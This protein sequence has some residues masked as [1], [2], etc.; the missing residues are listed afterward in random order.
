MST[1]PAPNLAQVSVSD[2]VYD[3]DDVLPRNSPLP[4]PHRLTLQLSPSPD[5]TVSPSTASPPPS[6]GKKRSNRRKKAMPQGYA[7][8][9]GHLDGHRQ[10]SAA[11]AQIEPYISDGEDA[12]DSDREDSVSFR[13][14]SP[15]GKWAGGGKDIGSLSKT[16]GGELGA[17]IMTSGSPAEE[18]MGA[19]RLKSLAASVLATVAPHPEPDAGPTPPVT[20]GDVVGGNAQPTPGHSMAIHTRRTE[21]RND[22]RNVPPAMPSPYTTPHSL[23]SPRD[24]GATPS[25]LKVDMRSP[26][27]SIHSSSHSDGLPPIQHNSPRYETNGQRLPSIRTQLGDIPPL[28]SNHV[29]GNGLRG[30]HPGFPGSPPANMPRLPS[31]HSHLGSPPLPSADPYRDPLSPSHPLAG[32]T[33]SPRYYLSPQANGLHRPH[34]YA[35]NSPEAIPGSHQPASPTTATGFDRMSIDG[36]TFQTT[37]NYRC[38]V[39]GCTALPFQTQYLLNSHANVHSSARPHY[40]PVQDCPRGEGGKGFKRKNE[41]IRHGLVHD[42]PGYICPFCPDR[43]HR[44]PRPDN[45]QRHVRVHHVDKDKDDAQLRA[46][47]A[48]RPNGPSR[49]RRRRGGPS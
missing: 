18:D 4:E 34:D 44:Y 27:A 16:S 43:D 21:P 33:P 14:A 7:I 9:I 35:G 2:D 12:D 22:E 25:S 39:P 6:P 13:D 30:P 41:M 49:G 3:P 17:R 38:K 42:S 31:L 37:G 24:P 10:D 20:D 46:V 29:A 45:L 26:T 23:Y 40:C 15:D 47:L 5:P 36:M 28:G 1:K 48:Q 32:P 19:F 11:Y 8:L